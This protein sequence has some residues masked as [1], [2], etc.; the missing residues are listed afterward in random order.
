MNTH[1]MTTRFKKST[2]INATARSKT[3]GNQGLRYGKAGSRPDKHDGFTGDFIKKKKDIDEKPSVNFSKEQ[4]ENNLFKSRNPDRAG[5]RK[6]LEFRG[7]KPIRFDP[8]T[9]AE[10]YAGSYS[11]D[12]GAFRGGEPKKEV[13]RFYE[14]PTGLVEKIR[15]GEG[16]PDPLRIKIKSG[17]KIPV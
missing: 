2:I 4:T 14:K 5:E 1:S 13:N 11:R 15:N 16:N 9:D 8:L 10:N 6:V 3:Y 12:A 7:D 17:I